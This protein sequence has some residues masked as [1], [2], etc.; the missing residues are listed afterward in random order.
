MSERKLS[1][2]SRIRGCMIGGAA[3]DAL[4]YP[5]EFMS[6]KEIR[7][8]FGSA[9][10]VDYVLDTAT[11]KALIS[12]DTQMTLFTANGILFRETRGAL[13]GIGA[14]L[15]QYLVHSY[16]DWLWTQVRV[17]GKKPGYSVSWLLD[18][19]EL[20]AQRA[21]GMTCLSALAERSSKNSPESF[22]SNPVNNSKGCG[23]VMRVAPIGLVQRYLYDPSYEA[24]EAAAI[25]HGHPLGF[26]SAG[27]LVLLIHNIVFEN[28]GLGQ[29]LDCTIESA[30][31]IFGEKP[32]F[33]VLK[34]ILEKAVNLTANNKPDSVNISE[35]GQGWIAE[36]ALAIAVYC[37]LRHEDS[38]SEG[39]IAAVNHDGD[40]DS[41]GAITGNI[42]GAYLGFEAVEEKWKKNLELMEV[43][44]ELAD[45]LYCGCRV[46]DDKWLNKY[47]YCIR[48]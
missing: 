21:P 47:L 1:L 19:P 33:T 2:Q 37:A 46:G 23:G 3:G 10:I 43:I 25:T 27:L 39:V 40:S 4:G 15:H 17:F 38:F 11:G 9:G 31:R 8:R 12:D 26:I 20:Y 6:E 30:E 29:A 48:N 16:R 35:L 7:T 24:A 42:L 44:L 28:M 22:C 13:K 5:V 18:V 32:A 14:D 41:T 45:D 34:A 36:E